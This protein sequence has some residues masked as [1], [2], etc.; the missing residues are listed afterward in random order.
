MKK[1][2]PLSHRTAGI[3]YAIRDVVVPAQKLEQQGHKILNLNIGDPLSHKGFSTPLHMI[4]AY[5]K[6]LQSQINGYSPSYGISE[7]REAIAYDEKGKKNGGWNCSANDVYVTTGVTE[8]L[9]IIFSTF[10]EPGDEVLIPG[11]YYPPYIAYP[12]IFDGIVKEYRL[13][14]TDGWRIDLN[15]LKTKLNNKVK[16]LILVNPNNPTGGI[17]NKEELE[18][19]LKMVN[20]YP[21]CS[22]ISDEIYDLYNFENNH[23]STASISSETP[24][25]TLNGVSKGY[26]APGWRVGYMAIHDPE[27]RLIEIRKGVEQL[28][29]SRL[30]APTPAQYGYLAGLTQDKGWMEEYLLKLLKHRDY[31]VNEINKIPGLQTEKPKGSFYMFPKILDDKYS[32]HDKKFVL[33]L[34]KK[35]HVLLVHG[36]GFSKNFGTGHFRIVFIPEINTLKE[37]FKRINRFIN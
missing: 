6:A 14:S 13:N 31:A 1:K 9:Q 23:I 21:N 29:R 18:S 34:L 8:A 25:I 4:E 16:L 33:D 36:S 30:C 24:V 2:I 32:N 20:T 17:V 37:A 11:P 19:I 28:L 10:L 5:K 27:N 12:P 35:E 7:L 22:I 3:Q 26:Y 15:D